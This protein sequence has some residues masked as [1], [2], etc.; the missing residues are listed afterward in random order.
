MVIRPASI[1]ARLV[2]LTCDVRKAKRLLLHGGR[3]PDDRPPSPAPVLRLGEV[4]QPVDG[5]H[6]AR[7][8]AKPRCC[9]LEGGQH[10]PWHGHAFRQ[11]VEALRRRGRPATGLASVVEN[12]L[13]HRHS[14]PVAPQG[15]IPSASRSSFSVGSRRA[16]LSLKR[17]R[18]FPLA[19]RG[20]FGTR[21]GGVQVPD[22]S[23]K[24][25]HEF[26]KSPPGKAGFCISGHLLGGCPLSFDQLHQRL[27]AV[28]QA[29]ALL[30][31]VDCLDHFL[32]QIHNQLTP[33]FEARRRR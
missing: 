30:E 26:H 22:A 16:S 10:L 18:Q 25:R 24:A 6:K 4:E 13:G 31:L 11:A 5:M 12:R 29:L 2:A 15:R 19:Y 27:A 21:L 17:K 8:Q 23:R 7:R 1:S 20:V 28:A 3:R 14:F 9:R 33:A 32:R